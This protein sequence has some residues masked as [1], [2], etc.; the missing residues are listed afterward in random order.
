[1]ALPKLNKNAVFLGAAILLGLVA[2][3]L[4]VSY[5]RERVEEATAAARVVVA[6]AQVVV[7][8]HDVAVGETVTEE[9]LVTRSVPVDFIPADVVTVEDY[10]Q[11]L[12]RMARAPIK[13]GAPLSASAL[14]PLYNQFSRV[15]VPGKVGYT[16]SVNENNSLSGMISPGDSVDILL[17]Y[18]ADEEGDGPAADQGER[19]VPLLE[20]VIVLATGSRVGEALPG[21][22]NVAF[23]SITLELDPDQAERLTVGQKTGDLRVLL[24]NIED[25]TPFGLDGL[26]EKA[27]MSTFGG[28]GID[29]VEYI[30]GGGK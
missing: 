8:A 26:T 14:V 17:T 13:S 30:I 18:E 15:V 19:V 16:L 27:L 11:Y 25:R 4:S 12:G 5:V 22:D 29:D 2:A 1:M 3:L 6:E 23:S 24:R 9:D 7:A 10:G 20:N 28:L 21:Q